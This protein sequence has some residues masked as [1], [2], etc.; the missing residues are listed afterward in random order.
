MSDDARECADLNE[1]ENYRPCEDI[2]FEVTEV[3]E[4]FEKK[5]KRRNYIESRE[6]HLKVR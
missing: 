6:E 5:K 1:M 4:I 3:K 2:D